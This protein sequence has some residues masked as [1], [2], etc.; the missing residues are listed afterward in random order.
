[1]PAASK[2]SDVSLS[3][4][5]TP[6]VSLTV[7]PKRCRSLLRRA[8]LVLL[9]G[10]EAGMLLESMSNQPPENRQAPDE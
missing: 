10:D 5:L 4:A 2:S 6:P 8:T 7:E 1:M 9:K 3:P